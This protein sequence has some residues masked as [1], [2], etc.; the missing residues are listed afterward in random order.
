MDGK[1]A[2]LKGTGTVLGGWLDY[3]FDR[4]RV[5]TCTLTLM[6]G[7]FDAT[8]S[9]P[10]RSSTC[11]RNSASASRGSSVSATGCASIVSGP[12]W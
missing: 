2:R 10:P 3:V 5:L 1:I 4:V 12:T 6:W 8:G 9:E 7:Q 11:K